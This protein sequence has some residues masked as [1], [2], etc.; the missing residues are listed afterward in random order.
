[1][2]AEVELICAVACV[3]CGLHTNLVSL[4]METNWLSI[5]EEFSHRE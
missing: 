4:F 1:M 5:L 3:I 2:Q